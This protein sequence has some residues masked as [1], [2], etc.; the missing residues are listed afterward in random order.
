MTKFT[1]AGKEIAL[2]E[3]G[4]L[5]NQEDWNEEVG[6]LL[7][8]REGLGPL[9]AEQMDIIRFMREYFLKYHVF[10]MLNNVCRIAKQP[11]QCVNEQFVNPEIAW[12]IAGLPRQDGIR[13]VTLDGKNYFMEPYG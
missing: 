8:K 2:D 9:T 1:H 3:R 10:P 7:A 11:K 5:L 13:F 6:Q 4:F 12:K